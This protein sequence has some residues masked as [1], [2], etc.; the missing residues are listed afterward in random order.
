MI[1]DRL[2]KKLVKAM[3]C[4]ILISVLLTGCTLPN[5]REKDELSYRTAGIKQMNKGDY[6]AA[7][8]AFQKALDNSNGRISD[9]ELDICYYKAYC[10][11][12]VGK[13]EEALSVYNAIIDY[14][15]NNSEAYLL[16]G[17][18]NVAL[19]NKDAALRD[20]D[21]AVS[22]KP[23]CYEYYLA[24]YQNLVYSGDVTEAEDYLRR[25]LE[26]KAG[27]AEEYCYQGRFYLLIKEYEA[28]KLVLS[29]A[30]N[31][32]SEEAKLYMASAMREM[33]QEEQA[34][35]IYENYV[36]SHENDAEALYQIVEILTETGEYE[37]AL[38]YADAAVSA[39][40]NDS[41]KKKLMENKIFCLEK[42][43]QYKEAINAVRTYLK[44][45]PD[46]QVMIREL[47]FLNSRIE[48][49]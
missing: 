33:G 49:P 46:D 8:S 20:Y 38:S 14:D 25:G 3:S 35:G 28:A 43:N 42:L 48:T 13:N 18:L 9:T 1:I 6:N 12:R 4:V 15:K 44:T 16:R 17:H 41:D 36:K 47:T 39:A 26:I 22:L 5:P 7:L 34:Y 24:I 19:D 2:G 40:T 30:M 32:G 29:N 27:T 31:E 45:F 37:K 10:L 11:I 23:R 21:K